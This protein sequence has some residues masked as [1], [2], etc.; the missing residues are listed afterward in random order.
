MIKKCKRRDMKR[1]SKD[2]EET[3]VVKVTGCEASIK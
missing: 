2:K 1:G 3:R